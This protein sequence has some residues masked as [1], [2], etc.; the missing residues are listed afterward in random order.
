MV[1]MLFGRSRYLYI[2]VNLVLR[3]TWDRPRFES[4]LGTYL[5][6]TLTTSLFTR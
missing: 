3:V 6:T 1:T 4:P 2:P 5:L